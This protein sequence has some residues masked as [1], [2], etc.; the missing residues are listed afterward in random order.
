MDDA[1]VD[2][3]SEVRR[4][5]CDVADRVAALEPRSWDSA[6]WCEGWRVR[7]VLGHLV[8]LAEANRRTMTLDLIRNG[9]VP[10][11]ATSRVARTLGDEPVPELADRLRAAAGG[12]YHLLGSP[13]KVVLGEVLV[14]GSDALRPLGLTTAATP[15]DAGLV[16]D[17][18]RRVAGLAFHASPLRGVRLVATDLDWQRGEGGEV[19]GTAMDLLL[20]IANRWAV[21]PFLRGPGMARLAA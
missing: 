12:R 15:Q 9:I 14:H 8:H 18:Y 1:D 16:L 7:D 6:S 2:L 4:L 19:T 21:L 20:L 11:R 17:Y 10:D 3:W 13:S 5:R